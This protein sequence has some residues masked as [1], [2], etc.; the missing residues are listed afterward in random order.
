MSVRT[1]ID[2]LVSRLVWIGHVF[3][4]VLPLVLGLDAWVFSLHLQPSD[5]DFVHKPSMID[6]R[7]RFRSEVGRSKIEDEEKELMQ[8]SPGSSSFSCAS[9]FLFSNPINLDQPTIGLVD[10]VHRIKKKTAHEG[11]PT[12]DYIFT[13]IILWFSSIIIQIY[14]FDRSKIE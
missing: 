5:L 9:S 3:S 8:Q 12:L 6:R 14:S 11:T 10:E 1:R 13:F 7:S 2:S 4:W